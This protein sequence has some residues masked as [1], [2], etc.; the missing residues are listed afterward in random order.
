MRNM[1][2]N[3][4]RSP[5]ARGFTLIELLVVIAII[6]IL[7]AMLLPAL[8]AAK[9]KAQAISCLS[10][11]KQLTLAWVMYSNDNSESMAFNGDRNATGVQTTPSW[12]YSSQV[13]YM[14]WGGDGYNTNTQFLINSQLSSM[15]DYIAKAVAI[16]R[17]PADSYVSSAQRAL[18]W[19]NRDRSCAMD[20][21]IGGGIKYYAGQTWFYNAKKVSDLHTPGPSD[22]WLFLDQHPDSI[23]DGS[24]YYNS[25]AATFMELPGSNHGGASGLSFAD[26]HSE[27]YKMKL[28]AIPVTYNDYVVNA[29]YSNAAD[30]AWFAQHT[31]QN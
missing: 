19:N 7:A 13:N 24:F 26:G 2:A 9:K 1:K 4:R 3:H 30:Q 28:G 14:T 6:A 5:R 15:G 21:A 22:C 10:N 16:F 8:A 25:T 23:D 29:K 11:Y 31:P 18:G 17:C 12:V 20:A 27:L